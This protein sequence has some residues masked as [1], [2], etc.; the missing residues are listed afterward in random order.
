MHIVLAGVMLVM[1]VLLQPVR[2]QNGA[3]ETENQSTN[4]ELG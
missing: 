2:L 4:G 3:Q 1:F